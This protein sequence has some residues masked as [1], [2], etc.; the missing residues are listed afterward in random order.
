VDQRTGL[1]VVA[2]GV[3]IVLLGL[4]AMAGLLGWVG[5]LPGDLRYS[6]GNVRVYAPLATMLLLS[7]VL[8]IVLNLLL[9][10]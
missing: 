2:A 3:V 8:T 1:Y 9:R 5:R 10:R 7:I 4:A 6:S